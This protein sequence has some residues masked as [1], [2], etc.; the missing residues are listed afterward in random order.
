MADYDFT[1][2]MDAEQIRR[3]KAAGELAQKH[4]KGTT[5]YEALEIG[6]VLLTGRALAMRV[7]SSSAANGRPR[8]SV[9]S[10][11]TSVLGST[12][13]ARNSRKNISTIASS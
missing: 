4:I 6:E 8:R 2:D 9:F 3:A 5:L 12:L 1:L 7:S 13:K 11:E 10:L